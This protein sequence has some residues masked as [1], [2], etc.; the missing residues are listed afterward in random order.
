MPTVCQAATELE[1]HTMYSVVLVGV[2]QANAGPA[3]MTRE[4]KAKPR[5]QGHSAQ[6]RFA[7]VCMSLCSAL[8]PELSR[9]K[10]PEIREQR[11]CWPSLMFLGIGPGPLLPPRSARRASVCLL[12]LLHKYSH[13]SEKWGREERRPQWPPWGGGGFQVAS[14]PWGLHQQP[15][16]GPRSLACSPTGN[17]SEKC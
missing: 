13:E 17:S 3:H 12:Y 1:L 16:G 2:P 11:Q 4:G 14:S 8:S 7:A 5:V 6:P 10:S 9:K 15:P